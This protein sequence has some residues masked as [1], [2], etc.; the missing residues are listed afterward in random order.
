MEMQFSSNVNGTLMIY[1]RL[2]GVGGISLASAGDRTVD[3]AAL[4]TRSS[5]GDGVEAWVEVTTATSGT[6]P[7]LSMSSYT[8][9]L[10]TTGQN[11][12]TVS[13]PAAATVLRSMVKFP[14]QVGD[15]GVRKCTTVNVATAGTTGDVN[16][17]LLKPIAF[18]PMY[19]NGS[20]VRSSLFEFMNIRELKDGASLS[21]A[22][23]CNAT[24][25][26]NLYGDVVISYA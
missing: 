23:L 8:N 25:A 5:G 10:G 26:P 22:F 19:A 7:V 4:P 17:I 2:V 9:E 21:F 15:K 18:L 13:F 16:F 14:L 12:G 11:S 6:A 24:T 20:S 1:D 3:S